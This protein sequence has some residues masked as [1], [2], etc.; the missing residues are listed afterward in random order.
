MNQGEET[1]PP[2]NGDG[3]ENGAT[4]DQ[5]LKTPRT[6]SKGDGS[7]TSG[8]ELQSL[9]VKPSRKSTLNLGYIDEETSCGMGNFKPTYLQR[10]ATPKSFLVV[11]SI[12]GILQ[13]AFFTYFIGVLSTLEKRFSFDSK[14][15]AIIILADNLSPVFTGSCLGTYRLIL[16]YFYG[17]ILILRRPLRFIQAG[18]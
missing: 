2:R 10:Y 7:E 18:N 5:G 17:Y 3:H 9:D 12:I 16:S 1:A 8:L 6:W 14:V 4:T 15:S 13:G 11:S